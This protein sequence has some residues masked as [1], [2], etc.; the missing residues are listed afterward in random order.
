[1]NKIIL[2]FVFVC[3]S[4][5]AKAQIK[6]EQ[7]DTLKL[8]KEIKYKGKIKT[9]VSF[10]DKAGKHIVITTETGIMPG[11][12]ADN[13]DNKTAE[14]YAY[15]Y[16]YKGDSLKQTWKI[17]DFIKDCMLDM[18]VSFLKNTFVVTDLNK[19]GEAEIW[20]MY[21]LGCRGDVGPYD[22][23]LIMYQG[24]KKHAMRGTVRVKTGE[25]HYEGGE[26]KFDKAFNEASKE[27]RDYAQKL[28]EKN[29]L[30]KND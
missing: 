28:W 22:L 10:T 8:P 24:N 14:L 17:T 25:N 12:I 13:E 2:L 1:M 11:N 21:S 29:K 6:L 19:D 15:H 18:Q 7:L 26:F 20:V 27:I 23:K 4:V 30:E 9:A 3:F 5:L 16:V